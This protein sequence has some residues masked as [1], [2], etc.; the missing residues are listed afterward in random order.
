VD[1]VAALAID[2]AILDPLG[3]Y[4]PPQAVEG[5]R[6]ISEGLVPDRKRTPP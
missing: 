3:R 2:H 6:V 1:P 5:C 4:L